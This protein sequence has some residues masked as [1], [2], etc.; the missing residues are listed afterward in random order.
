MSQES[1]KSLNADIPFTSVC[2]ADGQRQLHTVPG[3]VKAHD[4]CY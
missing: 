4:A 1:S 3:T 2:V